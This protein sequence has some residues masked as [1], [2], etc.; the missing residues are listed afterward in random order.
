MCE[1]LSSMGLPEAREWSNALFEPRIERRD[2]SV[3]Q[4]KKT[5]DVMMKGHMEDHD[6]LLDQCTE[7]CGAP[8]DICNKARDAQILPHHGFSHRRK[9]WK[10]G[11]VISEGKQGRGKE[12]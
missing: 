6:S 1:E 9:K 2:E 7:A 12:G 4:R 10:Q 11:R 3:G 8:L 5:H